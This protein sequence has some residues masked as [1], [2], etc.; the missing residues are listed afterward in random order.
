MRFALAKM[1]SGLIVNV[2]DDADAF[3]TAA[4]SASSIGLY[5]YDP[6]TEASAELS[7]AEGG[8]VPA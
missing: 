1:R 7:R 8:A 6:F 4:S 5:H 2:Y 3:Q